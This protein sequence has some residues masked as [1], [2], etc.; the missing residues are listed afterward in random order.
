MH[1]AS[2]AA[3]AAAAAA[4]AAAAINLCERCRRA[5]A[6]ADLFGD[7]DA[8]FV[9]YDHPWEASD[10]YTSMCSGAG[11]ESGGG[12]T[13]NGSSNNSSGGG[14]GVGGGT[15]GGSIGGGV[16]T[17]SGA[18]A[19]AAANPSSSS[20]SGS[21]TLRAPP[22]P[23]RQGDVGPRVLH[24]HYVLYKVG[25]LSLGRPCFRPGVFCAGTSEAVGKF[26]TDHWV[27]GMAGQLGVYSAVTR[28]VLLSILDE[29]ERRAARVRCSAIS[30]AEGPRLRMAL[31]A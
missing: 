28:T 3:S 17:V 20:T 5:L 7:D 15:S 12:G 1:S 22:P 8:S 18:G 10:E 9:V 25:Y 23:L 14:S 30:G 19:T 24:L 26:Q 31:A 21:D 16:S 2:R 11:L 4:A 29:Q 13:G 27:A 6:D